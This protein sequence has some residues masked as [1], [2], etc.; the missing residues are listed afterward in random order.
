M[1]SKRV[2]GEDAERVRARDGER[3]GRLLGG[4]KLLKVLRPAPPHL[5]TRLLNKELLGKVS[6]LLDTSPHR[7]TAA[8]PLQPVEVS[9]GTREGSGQHLSSRPSAATLPGQALASR[10]H[11]APPRALPRSVE[12]GVGDPAARCVNPHLLVLSAPPAEA[13]LYQEGEKE[14]HKTSSIWSADQDKGAA[15]RCWGA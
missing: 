12:Q 7:P 15:D 10:K 13:R 5:Q 4:R 1:V 14:G 3:E 9:S 6:P 11:L 2:G 8:F